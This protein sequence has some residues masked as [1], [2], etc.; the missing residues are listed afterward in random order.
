MGNGV[1]L[2]L[3]LK[4][5]EDGPPVCALVEDVSARGL[6]GLCPDWVDQIDY[7]GFV[8]LSEIHSPCVTWE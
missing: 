3:E 2:I 4:R 5:S 6:S 7:A 8:E 1:Y